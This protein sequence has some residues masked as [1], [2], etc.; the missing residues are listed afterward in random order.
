MELNYICECD[1]DFTG[2]RCET[3]IDDCESVN[4]SGRGE[5]MDR[6][7][8]FSCNC[9]QGYEGLLC[10]KVASSGKYYMYTCMSNGGVEFL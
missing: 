1:L 8:S 7:R 5:C 6:V 3:M 10:E 4:C 2:Q 9:D